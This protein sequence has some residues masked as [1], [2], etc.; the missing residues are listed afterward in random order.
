[1]KARAAVLH[2]VGQE[3]QIEEI[4]VDPPKAGEV[5]VEWKVAGLCHSDEH[6]VT[7]DMVPPEECWRWLGI[8]DFFPVV[9]GHEGAG[10]V[11]EVGPGVT[12]VQPATTC[13]PAS[14]RRADV[15]ATA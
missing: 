11:L 7:G 12:S 15:A 1:M 3:W 14:S 9:G 10:V 2:G 4:N 5:L 13:R 8:D 6:F